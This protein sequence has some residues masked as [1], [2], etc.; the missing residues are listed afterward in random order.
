L[1][2]CDENDA[3]EWMKLSE[4][5]WEALAFPSTREALREWVGLR[6]ELPAG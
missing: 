2:P 3:L 6:G 5:P 4:I 1:T